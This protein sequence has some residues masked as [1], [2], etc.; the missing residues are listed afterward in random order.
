MKMR[1]FKFPRLAYNWISGVGIA[2]ALVTAFLMTF[3][4]VIGIFAKETNPY[5]GIFLYMVMPPVLI[6]GLLLIPIGMIRRW[7]RVRK[8]GEEFYPAWPYIDLNRKTHLNAAII[9]V[10]GTILFLGIG[11]VG[12]YEAYHFT[13]SVPFCGKTCHEVMKPEYTAYQNSAHARVACVECHVGPGADWFAKS[14]LSGLYQVYAVMANV[15]P[16]PIPTPIKSLRPARETCEQCHWPGKFFGAQQRIFDH[17]MYNDENTHWPI[18]MLVKTGGGDPKT[19]QVSGIHWH[20]FISNKIEYIAR[21]ERRQEIPWVRATNLKTGKVTVFQNTEKPLTQAEIDSGTVRVLDCMDC[22]NRP[23]HVYDSPDLCIDRAI[24]IG[25][26]DKSLPDIKRVAVEAMS[27]EYEDDESAMHGIANHI[28]EYYMHE[29]P[30]VYKEKRDKIDQAVLGTQEQFS[31]NI[32]PFMKVRW[33]DYPNNIG[34]FYSQGCMRCH[35]GNHISDD[36]LSSIVRDCDACHIIIA[37]GSG[38][39]AQFS[40]TQEGLRFE[41]PEDIDE[42]WTEMGCYECHSGTQP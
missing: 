41:H 39:R 17:Y 26:V 16:K 5:L 37:Q 27:A 2:M 3:L 35:E 19:G 10:C 1:K 15:Y 22:H 31:Q 29:Y 40:G 21:D 28:T 4:Y 42:A 13:E 20:T 8:T 14:K 7:L 24:L 6:V 38:E 12:S 11:S 9:F 32:F 34:H 36:G 33:E 18:N 23:S 25:R 30:D